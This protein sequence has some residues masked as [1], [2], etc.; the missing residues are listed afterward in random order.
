MSD[1]ETK[2][3]AQIKAAN[4]GDVAVK[5]NVEYEVG[6]PLLRCCFDSADEHVFAAGQDRNIWQIPLEGDTEKDNVTELEGH[7]GWV[8]T[9]ATTS[10]GD[11]LL[12]GGSDGQLIWWSLQDAGGPKLNK[13]VVNAHDG[14]IRDIALS[15]DEKVL[16]TG[17][18]DGTVKVWDVAEG[19]LL[20]SIDGHKH[21]IYRVAFHPDGKQLVSGDLTC[22]I[23]CW[24]VDS[25]KSLRELH[26]PSLHRI[27][28]N[29]NLHLGGTRGLTFDE[30]GKYLAVSGLRAAPNYLGGAVQ[31]GNVIL[32]YAKGEIHKEQKTKDNLAT[33]PW[34]SFF[35]GDHILT[36]AM[37]GQAG[38]HLV[39]WNLDKEDE[40]F[41]HKLPDV[42]R[43]M[44]FNG[45][46]NRIATAHE[47][48]KLRISE[49]K[50]S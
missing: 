38:G 37:G 39:F 12:S 9:L 41:A 25:G 35:I 5:V 50:I 3:T 43:D 8:L 19:K 1:A 48:G 18:N 2:S 4:G 44:A 23:Q 11:T 15:P 33:V 31:P 27:D 29:H 40:F 22:R 24:D 30:N 34:E 17:G 49:L 45:Q 16:A 46:K 10:D 14:W 6:K 7:D 26:T 36:V 13:Q 42:A 32:D 21:H 47:D 28:K 20:Q